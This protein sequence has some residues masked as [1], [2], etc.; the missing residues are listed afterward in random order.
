MAQLSHPYMIP[1]K[2]VALTIGILSAKWCLCLFNI[3]SQFVRAFLPRSKCLLIS[4]LQS[5]SALILKPKKIK[6]C[7]CFPLFL[8][9]LPWSDGTRC[10]DLCFFECWVL[11]QLVHSPLSLSSRGSLVPLFFL[12]LELYH[13]HIWS[14]WYF[15]WQSWF[16]LLIHP[17]QHF[18]W[19]PLHKS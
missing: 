14:Y 11:S 9:Y 10:H 18:T 13:L 12:P 5:S 15:S 8:F 1:G 7:H 17:A 16:Q 19:C 6:I 4:W 3:L 2:T